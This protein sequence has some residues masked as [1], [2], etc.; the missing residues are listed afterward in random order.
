MSEHVA[1]SV[2]QVGFPLSFIINAVS[3]HKKVKTK[4]RPNFLYVKPTCYVQLYM[5]KRI[6]FQAI[7]KAH[8]N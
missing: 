1:K 5:K 7:N 4:C 6:F 2:A 3:S 8:I